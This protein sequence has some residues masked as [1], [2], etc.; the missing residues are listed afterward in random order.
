M[1]EDVGIQFNEDFVNVKYDMEKDADKEKFD[2]YALEYLRNNP[3]MRVLSGLRRRVSQRFM[4]FL[5]DNNKC[6]L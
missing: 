6:E 1:R 4:K 2:E 3:I 5:G